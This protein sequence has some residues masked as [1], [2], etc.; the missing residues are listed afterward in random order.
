MQERNIMPT[1]W[2]VIALLAMIGLHFLLP[3]SRVI[4]RPWNLLGLVP[5]V[6]GVILNLSADRAFKQAETTVKPFEESTALVTDGTFKISRNPMYL[7]FAL[8]LIGVAVLL[9]SVTPWMV[10]PLFIVLMDRAYIEVEERMM[11]EQFGH[12]WSRYTER[13]RRWV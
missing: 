5:L 7:G 8:I 11:A 12:A 6:I 9:G 10:L 1:A 2:L 4:P 3:V 13:T